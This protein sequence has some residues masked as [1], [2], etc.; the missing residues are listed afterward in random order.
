MKRQNSSLY[1]IIQIELDFNKLP[2]YVI[3]GMYDVL[4]NVNSFEFIIIWLCVFKHM[5]YI[6]I[7]KRLCAA[8]FQISS[9]S[10]RLILK[11]FY[12]NV[13]NYVLKSRNE[14]KEVK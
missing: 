3:D 11:R 5:S 9:E 7:T 10:I 12:K 4:D 13:E 8:G 14:K 1:S 2:Q 6:E